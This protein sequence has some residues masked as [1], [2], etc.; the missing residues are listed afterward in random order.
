MTA[1]K[2]WGVRGSTKITLYI[3]LRDMAHHSTFDPDLR[4]KPTYDDRRIPQ[5][6]AQNL[7][8]EAWAKRVRCRFLAWD[9]GTLPLAGK[10]AKQRISGSRQGQAIGSRLRKSGAAIV[11]AG[12]HL[13][14]EL[15]VAL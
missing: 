2:T 6:L 3:F 9:D 13:A 1:L 5:I 11:W 4:R 12:D 10:Y 7:A 8:V 15:G 14:G